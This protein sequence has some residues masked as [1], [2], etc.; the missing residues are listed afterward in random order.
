[1]TPSPTTPSPMTSSPMTPC[2]AMIDLHAKAC[3]ELFAVY[4]LSQHVQ[5]AAATQARVHRASYASV[6]SATGE[7]I[8]LS[9]TMSV[10]TELLARTHPSGRPGV[11][12]RELQD[13]CRELNNPLMGRV[14]NKLLRIGCEVAT[15]LPVLVSGTDVAAVVAPELDHRQ[16][17][18]SS[19]HG[20]MSFT[21]AMQ[22][23]PDFAFAAVSGADALEVKRE[24]ELSL[25]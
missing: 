17:F 2:A 14:K 22:L 11:P 23:A 12:D 6:L 21:L 9:S 1:M 3:S 15:G 24:G 5:R 20:N 13:W 8:R 7:G 4:G 19:Q 18:F 25:F 10:D 16:Y